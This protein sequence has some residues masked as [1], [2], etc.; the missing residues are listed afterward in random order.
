[1]ANLIELWRTDAHGNDFFMEGF[2]REEDAVAA[3][4]RFNAKGH[5]QTYWLKKPKGL[6]C[7]LCDNKEWVPGVDEFNE[8]E[9]PFP[10]PMCP[11]VARVMDGPQEQLTDKERR[12]SWAALRNWL[13]GN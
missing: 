13:Y 7:P 2:E 1:M 3:R 5:K 10:C 11:T 9:T 8:E 4:A 6:L 12:R